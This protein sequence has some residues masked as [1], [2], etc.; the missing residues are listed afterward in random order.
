MTS[1]T[2]SMKCHQGSFFLFFSICY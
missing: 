2:C 1:T